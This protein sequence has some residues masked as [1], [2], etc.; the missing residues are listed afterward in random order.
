MSFSNPPPVPPSGPK[1]PLNYGQPYFAPPPKTS[2]WA[3]AAMISSLLFC[4][5]V[6]PSLAAVLLAVVAFFT[7]G[8]P[9]RKGRGLATAALLLGLVG[10]GAWGYA[11]YY[12]VDRFAHPWQTL[13]GFSRAVATGDTVAA[14]AL[15]TP[16]FDPST[17]PG[18]TARIKPLG[19]FRT[20]KLEEN[21]AGNPFKLFRRNDTLVY[22]M[23]GVLE[24]E[25]GAQVCDVELESTPA[26]WRVARFDLSD[27][28]AAAT[29]PGGGGAGAGASSEAKPPVQATPPVP[30]TPP[31]SS[32]GGSPQVGS[33]KIPVQETPPVRAEPAAP[34]GPNLVTPTPTPVT[35][36]EPMVPTEPVKPAEP[37]APGE[38]N[39]A[40][41]PTTSPSQPG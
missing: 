41:P 29:R 23:H 1:Q 24:F 36:A 22:A 14:T 20:L 17:I 15:T 19:A 2:G 37:A 27:A 33:P 8:R 4:I 40:T 31:G 18:L 5:P 35:P 34:A 25:N 6:V 28:P 13:S 16:P 12:V 30:V 32:E 3:V 10:L 39:P 9:N 26:G 21:G 38:P 7:S 11:G